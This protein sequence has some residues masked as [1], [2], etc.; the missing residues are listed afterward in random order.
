[1]REEREVLEGFLRKCA[2]IWLSLGATCVEG[3][4]GMTW[5]GPGLELAKATYLRDWKKTVWPGL[6]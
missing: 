5:A 3:A 4:E 1:M 2:E 6:H